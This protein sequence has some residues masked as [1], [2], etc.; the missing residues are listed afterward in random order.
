LLSDRLWSPDRRTLTLLF[1]PGRVK[2]GLI[3]QDVHDAPLSAGQ[4]VT[5]VV[6]GQ[7]AHAWRV[8]A[9]GCVPPNP[10]RWRIDPPA[11]ATLNPL[12]VT[13][14]GAIDRQS[15][16]LIAVADD[17]GERVAGAAELGEGESSWSF[18]P[19]RPW[20][21]GAYQIVVHP[22]L[23][24]PCG[25]EIGEGFQHPAGEALGSNRVASTLR[26]AVE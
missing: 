15:I 20:R 16:A 10:A 19:K 25:D 13:L 12:T 8:E 3:A 5:L 26:F 21:R 6:G 14:S 9:G 24:N 11:A 18:A 17:G 23:E 22:R 4:S 7:R 1:D 2:S